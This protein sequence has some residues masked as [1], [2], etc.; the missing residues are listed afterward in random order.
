MTAP[1]ARPR[2]GFTL[3]ELLVVIAIIALLVGLLLPAVQ[4]AREAARK[5]Q[6]KNNLKQIGIALHN[7]HDVHSIFPKRNYFVGPSGNAG[8]PLTF[9]SWML[10]ILPFLEENAVYERWDFDDQLGS[11]AAPFG[12]N[13]DLVAEVIPTYLAASTP[14]PTTFTAAPTG[15]TPIEVARTDFAAPYVSSLGS[16]TGQY[17]GLGDS[18]TNGV[19]GFGGMIFAPVIDP[20]APSPSD[21]DNANGEAFKGIRFRNIT[22][23]TSNTI[24]VI[25]MA[26]LPNADISGGFDNLSPTGQLIFTSVTGGTGQISGPDGFWAGRGAADVNFAFIPALDL[27]NC[28]VNCLNWARAAATP[29]SYHTG[30]AHALFADGSVQFLGESTDQIVF[31]RMLNRKDGEVLDF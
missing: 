9:S 24:G 13:A 12:P 4:Q 3:I 16:L 25:E 29:F 2:Y 6:T 23:G 10:H 28:V 19:D 18:V 8:D 5:T 22:D 26:G 20:G 21:P 7:Y 15:W 27:G 17:P 31:I 14:G 30:G 11:I 1:A